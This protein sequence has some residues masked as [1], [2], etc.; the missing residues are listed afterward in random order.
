[1]PAGNKTRSLKTKPG[2]LTLRM[3]EGPG[4]FSELV[5]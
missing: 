1:M 3:A 4:E 2:P 5:Q